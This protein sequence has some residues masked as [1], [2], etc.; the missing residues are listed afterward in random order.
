MPLSSADLTEDLYEMT[1]HLFASFNVR[2][3]RGSD[4]VRTEIG[5]QPGC[6]LLVLCIAIRG[7]ASLGHSC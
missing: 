1:E 7:L 3:K 5:H 6:R 4:V 2:L